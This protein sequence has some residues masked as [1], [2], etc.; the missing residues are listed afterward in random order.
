MIKRVSYYRNYKKLTARTGIE[1]TNKRTRRPRI[2]LFLINSIAMVTMAGVAIGPLRNLHQSF[3][4]FILC[5]YTLS[6]FVSLKTGQ[7]NSMPT[8]T[9]YT[10]VSLQTEIRQK[11]LN[12]SH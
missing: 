7:K 12:I 10:T 3:N 4:Q 11:V 2:T 9:G 6:K 5:E 1:N 8:V